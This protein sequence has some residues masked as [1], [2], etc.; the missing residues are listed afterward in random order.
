MKNDRQMNDRPKKEKQT[1]RSADSVET[2]RPYAAPTLKRL[3]KM[4]VITAGSI[5]E[6]EWK[7][8]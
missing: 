4:P 1:T 2:R 5:S 6:A 8:Q 7:F 3:A